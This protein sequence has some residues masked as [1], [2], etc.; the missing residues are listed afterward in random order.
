MLYTYSHRQ[1][2]RIINLPLYLINRFDMSD[3][4]KILIMVIMH[5]PDQVLNSLGY[6]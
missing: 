1:R 5:F 3:I 4:M 2:G 6:A